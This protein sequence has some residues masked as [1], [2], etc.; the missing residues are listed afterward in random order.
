M[1]KGKKKPLEVAETEDA[2]LESRL[3]REAQSPD[4]PSRSCKAKRC[5]TRTK[6]PYLILH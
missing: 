6:I 2:K 5:R 3:L 1:Y 4:L